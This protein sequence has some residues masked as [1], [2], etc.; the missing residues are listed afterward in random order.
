MHWPQIPRCRLIVLLL[1]C[2]GQ[3]ALTHSSTES[4]FSMPALLR[5]LLQHFE[6]HLPAQVFEADW[7]SERADWRHCVSTAETAESLATALLQ[8]EAGMKREAFGQRWTQPAFSKVCLLFPALLQLLHA[9]V[10]THCH[11]HIRHPFRAGCY[12][13]IRLVW[14]PQVFPCQIG[15]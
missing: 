5:Y 8:L 10:F 1:M 11:G 14:L 13:V 7:D 12:W 15:G 2:A 4:T 3:T 6:V 9:P